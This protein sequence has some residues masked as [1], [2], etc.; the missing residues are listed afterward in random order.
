MNKRERADVF[1]RRL[2]TA[3]AAA[4][5][6]RSR[7][8]RDTGF[9]RST[10]TQILNGDAPRL[11]NAHLAAACA[12]AL[13]VSADWLLGLS[14]WREQAADILSASFEFRRAARTPADEFVQS[15][16]REAEGRKVRHVPTSL[17]DGMKTEAVL[18]YEYR[19]FLGKTPQQAITAM[20]DRL[21]HIRAPGSDIEFC[22][23][24]DV[25]VGFARG[26]GYW[27]GLSASARQEQLARIAAICRSY[28]PSVRLYLFDAK[29]LYS[30][31]LAIFGPLLAVVYVGQFY[32]VF[33]Q[34][35]QVLAF[36][37]HFDELI[38]GAHV[39][40]R[41]LPDWIETHYL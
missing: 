15:C 26:D 17:P 4:G 11:P 19:A 13:G 1:R 18:E 12:E 16:Y 14:D 34:R 33:R 31:P 9:D 35:Q 7:L 24:L 28:Y 23:R 32:T 25:L 6:S 20:R 3:L 21:E 40:A 37:Q 39:D 5:S 27:E 29:R 2:A 22:V 8:A 41:A 10:L 36:S 38:R 30:A